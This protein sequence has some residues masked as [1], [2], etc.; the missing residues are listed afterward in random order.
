MQAAPRCLYSHVF[1]Q[2]LEVHGVG[3][4][5]RH[6][7]AS[8]STVHHFLSWRCCIHE[9]KGIRFADYLTGLRYIMKPCICLPASPRFASELWNSM[10]L[11]G[12]GHIP[13]PICEPCILACAHQLCKIV[14][15]EEHTSESSHSGEYRMPSSA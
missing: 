6:I 8:I 2:L 1:P 5:L 11:T 9:M 7:Q 4:I 13:V 14:R 3:S 15:S 10:K 12:F